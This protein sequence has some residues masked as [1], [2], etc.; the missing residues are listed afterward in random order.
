MHAPTG[1]WKWGKLQLVL[2]LLEP[3]A[4]CFNQLASLTSLA[5]YLVPLHGADGVHAAP[6]ADKSYV[7]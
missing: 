6:F 3:R 2:G 1:L 5:A 7:N 4:A